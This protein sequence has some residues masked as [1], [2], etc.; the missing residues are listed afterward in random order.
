MHRHNSEGKM[1]TRSGSFRNKKYIYLSDDMELLLTESPNFPTI[2]MFYRV[3]QG[4]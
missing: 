3:I 4:T 2:I 1:I